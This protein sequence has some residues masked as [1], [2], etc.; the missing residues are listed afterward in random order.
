M[1]A[2]IPGLPIP[3]IFLQNVFEGKHELF[4]PLRLFLAGHRL[5]QLVN[6]VGKHTILFSTFY[7]HRNLRENEF[8]VALFYRK[9]HVAICK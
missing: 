5:T 8:A 9:E 1:H 3:N 7:N 4:V 6:P 2:A